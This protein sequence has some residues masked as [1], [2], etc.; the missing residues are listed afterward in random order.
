[1]EKCFLHPEFRSVNSDGHATY[2]AYRNQLDSKA[3]VIEA[4]DLVFFHRHAWHD[5]SVPFDQ[6]YADQNDQR[7]YDTGRETLFRLNPKAKM[8][9]IID[10]L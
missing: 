5:S 1:M 6:T 3:K 9:D 4:R 8:D 7:W 2:R 10:W